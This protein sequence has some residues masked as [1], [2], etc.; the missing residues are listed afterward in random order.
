MKIGRVAFDNQAVVKVKDSR[1]HDSDILGFLMQ[2][3]AVRATMLVPEAL[4]IVQ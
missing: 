4:A 1:S 2:R 3:S